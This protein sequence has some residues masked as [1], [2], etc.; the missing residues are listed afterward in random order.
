MVLGAQ[1]D[2]LIEIFFEYPQYM[3]DCTR[4]KTHI[5]ILLV[6]SKYCDLFSFILVW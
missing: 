3:F 6:E 2:G 5:N 1:Q 4:G